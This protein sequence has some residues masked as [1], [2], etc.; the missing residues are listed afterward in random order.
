ML[1][2][3]QAAAVQ[4][5]RLTSISS[6]KLTLT[7]TYKLDA[8]NALTAAARVNAASIFGAGSYPAKDTF[9]EG[10]GLGF[11]RWCC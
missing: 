3:N 9:E 1:Q 6:D 7:L 4:I 2:K 8:A 5:R 10:G 11:N